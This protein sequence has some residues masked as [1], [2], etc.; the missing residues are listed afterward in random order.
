MQRFPTGE[1]E[2]RSGSEDGPL[3]TVSSGLWRYAGDSPHDR[4]NGEPHRRGNP[5]PH[6]HQFLKLGT[7]IVDPG[8]RTVVLL[9][10]SG[11]AP[12][13]GR[14]RPVLS[15]LCRARRRQPP[16]AGRVMPRRVRVGTRFVRAVTGVLGPFKRVRFPPPPPSQRRFDPPSWPPG[17]GVCPSVSSSA[18]ISIS[19]WETL[20]ERPTSGVAGSR[21]IGPSH[22]PVLHTPQGRLAFAG[23]WRPE[24]A[25]NLDLTER[26]DRC[27]VTHHD[28]WRRCRRNRVF[29]EH[30]TCARFERSPGRSGSSGWS[31]SRLR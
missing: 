12:D 13:E 8:P 10:C 31:A 25:R 7:E 2:L 3:S 6:A 5:L 18:S 19:L 26:V 22:L 24:G 14:F 30:S 4:Q 29:R 23:S 1:T 11:L 15:G 28:K 27:A 9:L 20:Q 16:V 17:A 21:R